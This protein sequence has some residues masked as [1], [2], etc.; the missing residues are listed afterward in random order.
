MEIEMESDVETRA[1]RRGVVTD[2]PIQRG[3]WTLARPE[4]AGKWWIVGI[5]G[6]N[7]SSVWVL[8]KANSHVARLSV[9]C[10]V[11]CCHVSR[12][13][14]PRYTWHLRGLPVPW[15]GSDQ[16]IR[17][18]RVGIPSCIR[19]QLLKDLLWNLKHLGSYWGYWA[20]RAAVPISRHI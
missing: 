3:H 2:P 6:S 5:R 12:G 4:F 7:C 17:P 1:W 9:T 19:F 18:P 13:L 20:L 16:T 15:P 8:A 10:H 14:V 11:A